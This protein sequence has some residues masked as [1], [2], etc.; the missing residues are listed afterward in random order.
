[1]KLRLAAAMFT[2]AV[3]VPA[4]MPP[5]SLSLPKITAAAGGLAV[6]PLQFQS[7]DHRT[8]GIQFDLD[9]DKTAM[10]I[11]V[12]SGS[13]AASVRH[14]PYTSERTTGKRFIVV[15]PNR[16]PFADGALVNLFIRFKPG[17]SGA[18]PL[19]LLNATST[20][21][22]GNSVDVDSA[23]GLVVVDNTRAPQPV[24]QPEGVLNAASFL[25]GPVSPGE[26]VTLFGDQLSSSSPAAIQFDGIDSTVL[27]ASAT[28]INAVTP[29]AIAGRAAVRLDVIQGAT[30]TA[31]TSVPVA[32]SAP[33]IFT[34][35]AAG[36]GQA[37]ALNED[38][39]AN[40]ADNGAVRG[41]AVTIWLTGIPATPAAATVLVSGWKADI[42]DLSQG[43]DLPGVVQLR[44]TVPQL[45]PTAHGTVP[46]SVATEGVMTQ[47][48]V[49][50]TVR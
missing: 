28:Q 42:I 29:D 41:T 39:T 50:I 32:G 20:D 38:G 9:Y 37:L 3:A 45:P 24:L 47:S 13:A 16:A 4:R 19:T 11:G 33:G 8:T 15:D 26:I 2:V 17:I 40:G 34:A 1:M 21:V 6:V 44:F 23:S 30:I 49:F 43:A 5:C 31:S 27:Y 14:N 22:D 25:P 12:L 48:G 35:D 36:A 7:Q 46:L 10:N 18:Y